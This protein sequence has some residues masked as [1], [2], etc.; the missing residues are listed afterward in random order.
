MTTPA[1]GTPSTVTL[2][3]DD[4]RVFAE[5][6][7]ASLEA[8]GYAA[9]GAH[10][11][12]VEGSQIGSTQLVVLDEFLENWTRPAGPATTAPEDGLAVGA[13]LRSQ[14]PSLSVVILTGD[15][16]RLA[17]GVPVSFGEHHVAFLRDVEWVFSK[18]DVRSIERIAQLADAIATLPSTLEADAVLTW[19]AVP[20]DDW[21][22]D[23]VEHITRCRPPIAP[24]QTIS[25]SRPLLR[26]LLQRALPY[27]T[28]LL[29]DRRAAMALGLSRT[30]LERVA[31]APEAG[32]CVYAG[33]LAAFLGRRW[34]RAGIEHLAEQPE[35]LPL[36]AELS[37]EPGAPLVMPLGD[38]LEE[39]EPAPVAE[40]VRIYPDGWPAFS[41]QAWALR[42]DLFPG[43]LHQAMLGLAD[44][45]GAP[46]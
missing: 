18:T 19:L 45:L 43:S 34:W 28:F 36:L 38:D 37:Q 31:E 27:P 41:D 42:S 24:R 44:S 26:W 23:A 39:L 2:F 33:P 1:E 14:K 20:S 32:R 7:A 22:D 30:D 21:R 4:D 5:G 9:T 15:I 8:L 16:A 46:D 25:G 17:D 6:A 29:T 11:S 35:R 12:Q 10:P 3:V 40:C 13:V